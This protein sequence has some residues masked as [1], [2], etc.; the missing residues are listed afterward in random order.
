MYKYVCFIL[1]K[2]HESGLQEGRNR[3]ACVAAMN[4]SPVPVFELGPWRDM[5]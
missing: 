2:Q 3:F 5:A 1:Q 4:Q